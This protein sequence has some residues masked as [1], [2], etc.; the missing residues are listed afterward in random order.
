MPLGRQA[1]A[2][3]LENISKL[4]KAAKVV[5]SVAAAT[6]NLKRSAVARADRRRDI[7]SKPYV[8]SIPPS[9]NV[10]SLESRPKREFTF[11][12]RGVDDARDD[13]VFRCRSSRL[14]RVHVLPPSDLS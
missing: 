5:G 12:T 13:G 3:A 14:V 1:T 6:E 10:A 8:T 9:S 7:L 2:R 11:C 4:K